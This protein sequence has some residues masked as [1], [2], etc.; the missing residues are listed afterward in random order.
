[1]LNSSIEF[2]TGTDPILSTSAA[3]GDGFLGT[4]HL[5]MAFFLF[6]ALNK[7]CAAIE[8]SLALRIGCPGS[9]LIGSNPVLPADQYFCVTPTFDIFGS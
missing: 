4:L 5:G 7:A 6:D 9:V 8:K 1:M 3:G 2:R